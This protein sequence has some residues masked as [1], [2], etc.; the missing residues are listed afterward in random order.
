M[1]SKIVSA[2]PTVVANKII[3][4]DRMIDILYFDMEKN[5]LTREC[6]ELIH[7]FFSQGDL[8]SYTKC[9]LSMFIVIMS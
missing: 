7:K 8:I 3:T 1:G 4:R 6:I 9:F 5:M 2:I